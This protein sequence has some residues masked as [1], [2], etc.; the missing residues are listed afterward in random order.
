MPKRFKPQLN[1][2]GFDWFYQSNKFLQDLLAREVVLL[3]KL[4]FY[5][6]FGDLDD[7][8]FTGHCEAVALMEAISGILSVAA[9]IKM[10]AG[11]KAPYQIIATLL[12]VEKN[13]LVI[14]THTLEPEALGILAR[15]YQR[16]EEPP[17]TF[18]FD[19]DRLANTPVP[20][21]EQVRSAASKAIA[22]LKVHA[23]PGRPPDRMIE[24]LALNFQEIFLRFNDTITRHSVE[25]SRDS[26]PVQLEAGPFVA[27]LEEVLAPL[28]RFFDTLP[29]E[30]SAKPT[31][32]GTIAEYVRVRRDKPTRQNKS[33][34]PYSPHKFNRELRGSV[35]FN[36]RVRTAD[37]SNGENTSDR[38]LH[39]RIP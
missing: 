38:N 3:R 17:G 1:H 37:D 13:P 32:A 26:K 36:R 16:A 21:L 31:S 5:R 24:Y 15:C 20:D 30:Y 28:N 33:S 39:R 14:L 19:I 35:V 29:T 4:G 22:S 23:S 27:F 11:Y 25:S 10:D 8:T 12:A 2:I 6:E 34:M 18:W 7:P 9:T